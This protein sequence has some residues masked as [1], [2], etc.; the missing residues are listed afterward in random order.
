MNCFLRYM[1][2]TEPYTRASLFTC[3]MWAQVFRAAV[4]SSS[5]RNLS[6]NVRLVM[7]FNELDLK[8]NVS[9]VIRNK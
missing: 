8:M 1:S 2:F 5:F 9:F 3:F 4:V 6:E 7:S